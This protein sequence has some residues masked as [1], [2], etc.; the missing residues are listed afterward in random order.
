MTFG[1]PND[2]AIEAYH[3]TSSPSGPQWKGFGEFCV[4]LQGTSLG[5]ID[6]AHCSLFHATNRFRELAGTIDS[7]WDESFSGLSDGEIFALLDRE[8]YAE[9]STGNRPHYQ[10]FDFLTNTGEMFN[11]WKTFIACDPMGRVHILCQVNNG[12]S[13]SGTCDVQTFRAVAE[14]YVQWF[15]EQIDGQ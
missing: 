5:D 15:D 9:E 8:L 1:E 11:R 14:A 6:E 3:E 2:F 12:T 13:A 7:L 10:R 4:H